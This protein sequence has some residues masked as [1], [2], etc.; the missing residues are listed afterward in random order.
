MWSLES[1]LLSKMDG[2]LNPRRNH[3]MDLRHATALRNRYLKNLFLPLKAKMLKDATQ[4][5][6]S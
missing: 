2:F 3:P 1:E 4:P 5:T 6:R